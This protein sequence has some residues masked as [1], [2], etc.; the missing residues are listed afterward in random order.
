[1]KIVVPIAL[2]LVATLVAVMA[3]RL[4]TRSAFRIEWPHAGELTESA[5]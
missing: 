3:S 2:S 1:M 4:I 5:S